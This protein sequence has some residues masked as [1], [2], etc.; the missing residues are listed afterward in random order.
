MRPTERI[1]KFIENVP[2][3]TRA[4]RDEEVLDDV[5]NAMERSRTVQSAACEPNIWRIIMRSSRSKL[6]AAIIIVG[7]V[8]SFFVFDKLGSPAWAFEQAIEA[9]RDL[10]AVHVVGVF[11][12]GTAEMWMRANEACTQSTDVVVKGSLGAITWTKDGSTYHYEPSQNTVYFEN[13]ITIGTAQWLGPELLEMLSQAEDAKIVHGKDAA[14]GR[15]RVMLSC[16]M[17]DVHGPQSWIVEF[18]VATKLPVA[19]KQW[20]NLDRSGPPKFDAFK[21]TYYEDLPD[22]AFD[23][24]IPGEPAHV[25]KPLTIPDE[26]IGVLSNPRQGISAEGMTQQAAA[27]K[28]VRAMYLAV[29]DMD[30]E[31]LKMLCPLCQNWGDDFLRVLILRPGKDDRIVEILEIGA[32]CRTGRSKLGLI[33]AIPV[34]Y[35]LHNGKRIE[36]KMIVQFRQVGGKSSCVVHGPYGLPRELEY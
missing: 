6:A 34:V 32:I 19:F 21:L 31:Q 29:L 26:N 2:L 23:V 13:A 27:Q 17:T 36:Q 1:E 18:D 22:S 4:E 14:T 10:R 7:V 20:Q 28:A 16:S 15:N 30:L 3:E 35:R 8:S 5:F 24:R 11:P 12:G 25:E 9:L 33:T